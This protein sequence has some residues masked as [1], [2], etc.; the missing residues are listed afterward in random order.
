MK[1]K[2]KFSEGEV[3][4]LKHSK[5]CFIKSASTPL[6]WSLSFFF[7]DVLSTEIHRSMNIIWT[8]FSFLL[9]SEVLYLS[10]KIFKRKY[11]IEWQCNVED[12]FDLLNCIDGATLNYLNCLFL[13]VIL[14]KI[15]FM[16]IFL[17]PLETDKFN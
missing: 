4:G 11:L 1:N 9:H 14:P 16:I 13:I 12:F 17:F 10:K 6:K 5:K 15:E 8:R 3:E 7:E 2:L